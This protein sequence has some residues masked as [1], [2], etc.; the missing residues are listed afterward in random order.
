MGEE[1]Q[2]DAPDHADHEGAAERLRETSAPVIAQLRAEG[3]L[4][5]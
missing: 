1:D 3:K 5:R 4:R 2:H